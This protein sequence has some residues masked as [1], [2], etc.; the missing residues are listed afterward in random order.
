M[1][2]QL[3]TSKSNSLKTSDQVK[4]IL[5]E[6][7]LSKVFNFNEYRLFRK[8]AKRAFNKAQAVAQMFIE[9][10]QNESDLLEYEF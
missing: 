1:T 5:Q 2:K 7:G 8:R 9:E 10:Y 6:Q 4:L 3:N